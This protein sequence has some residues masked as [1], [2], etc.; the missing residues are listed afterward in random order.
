MWDWLKGEGRIDWRR[1]RLGGN[2][3]DVLRQDGPTDHPSGQP[4]TRVEVSG[5]FEVRFVPSFNKCLLSTCSGPD[6]ELCCW[7]NNDD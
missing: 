7:D 5:V 3:P 6:A 2:S 1:K 4:V